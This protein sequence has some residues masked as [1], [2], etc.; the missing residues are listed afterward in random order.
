MSNVHVIC[1]FEDCLHHKKIQY[2]ELD[3]FRRHLARDHDRYDLYQFAFDKGII[4]DPIRFH[5]PSYV[6]QKIADFSRVKR[7]GSW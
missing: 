2:T 6:I 3:K 7:E 5:N 1:P 4:Q